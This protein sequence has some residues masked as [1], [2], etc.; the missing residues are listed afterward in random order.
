MSEPT[1][2]SLNNQFLVAMPELEDPNFSR[3][4]TLICQHDS[5][6]ALGIIINRTIAT[7][8]INDI[9]RQCSLP[10][11]A[12]ESIG[13]K[14][15]YAGGPVHPE[16]GLVL[17]RSVGKWQSTL[18]IGAQ[19]GLTSSRDV[20]EAIVTSGNPDD[21]ILV[22]GYAGWEA[23][24]LDRE[25]KQNAWLTVP[26]NPKIIFDVSVEQ[27]WIEAVSFLGVDIGTLSASMG[28]A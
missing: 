3:T 19:L 21:C 23:G 6:G 10:K 15:I 16:L 9:L 24:Q 12:S 8:S 5:T 17:H 7:L 4:V 11:A 18:N 14:P 2:Q 13:L 20:L 22:L 1:F 25:I 27:R 28:H 26:A